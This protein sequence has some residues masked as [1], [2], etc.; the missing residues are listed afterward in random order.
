MI[1]HPI[2][3][4]V[5]RSLIR[6]EHDTGKMFWKTRNSQHIKKPCSLKSW[7]TRY[8]ETEITTLDNKGYLFCS[9][10]GKQYR[11]HRLAWLIF[12]GEWPNFIDHKDGI[13]TN[14]RIDNLASVTVQQ[15]HMNLSIASNNTSGV[16]GVYFNKK[17]GIW[18][19][20]MKFN[21]ITYHLGSS[22]DK[23]EAIAMRLAEQEKLGFSKRHGTPNVEQK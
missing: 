6:Y 22:R 5:A 2:S 14:N 3:V 15:N 7:N 1:I 12:Y 17:R 9:I 11:A 19:A 20:Q 4:D 18:C 10:Y 16:T 8:A 13:R 23:E 21:G